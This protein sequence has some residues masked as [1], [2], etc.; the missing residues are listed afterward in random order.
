MIRQTILALLISITINSLAAALNATIPAPLPD[1][2]FVTVKE[3]HLSYNGQRLRLWGT[4]VVCDIKRSVGPE[5]DLRFDRL[6]DA[7]FNGL[8]LNLFDNVTFAR[9][10]DHT[11]P[12]YIPVTVKGSD[13][14]MDRLDYSIY[15]A[16]QRGLFFWMSLTP[17]AMIASDYD[18]LPDDGTRDR[19][20]KAIAEASTHLM[21]F[22]ERAEKVFQEF[23]RGIVEHVNPYTGKRYADEEAIA[24]YELS[25]ENDFVEAVQSRGLPGVAGE[26]L[27]AKWNAYLKEKYKTDDRLKH[28]WT[29]LN[30]GESLERGTVA[31]QPIINGVVTYRQGGV[32][33]EYESADK[34]NLTKYSY[35]RGEDL[36][37]FV[38]ELY[39]NHT[40]RMTAFL[41][42]LAKPGVGINVVPITPT[43][44]YGQ[45][46]TTY[47]AAA[48]G[49][50]VSTGVYGFALRPWELDKKNKFY[51]YMVRSVYHPTMEQPI[52]L[53]RA[54]NKPY[55]I[56]ECNDFRPNPYTT[57]FIARIAAYLIHQD[58]D[59]AFWFHWDAAGYLPELKTD[60]DYA[61]N[62]RLPIPDTNYPNA[63]IIHANDEA[64]LAATKAMGT[65]FKTG[66]VPPASNPVDITL[67]KDI[68]FNL[69]ASLQAP[70]G[71][72]G[73][74]LE[75]LIREKTWRYGTRIKYDPVGP[76]KLPTG[77]E[78]H[79]LI[80][81]GPYMSY[82]W[83]GDEGHF[84]VDAPAAK[85]YTGF[86]KP[87]LDFKNTKLTD[88]DR[89]FGMI[90]IV[91]E[92]GL[93]LEKSSSIL[94]TAVSRGRNTGMEVHPENL[95]TADVWQQGLAQMCTQSGNTPVIVDRIS[96][97]ITAPW[98]KGMHVEK[99][100]FLRKTF[101][102]STVTNNTLTLKA[103]EPTFYIRLTRTATSKSTP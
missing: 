83:N 40:R 75:A 15:L 30:A 25:N 19:W 33:K 55:L 65:L 47:Y 5:L 73:L 80:P 21:V 96:A 17:R 44:R 91:A 76:S 59:G 90:A 31:F 3:G 81:M 87:T 11:S 82:S 56:Y 84:R 68:L 103:D 32:Q 74:T 67:G 94:I 89:D 26:M 16:H 13:S 102:R 100:D 18:V 70:A 77:R 64:F 88:I 95:N 27:T 14:P 52:D 57:E 4:N 71:D 43:G 2:K 24:L 50:F 101:D 1:G 12:S 23:A 6:A 60:E 78:P 42:S 49:D 54:K 61:R 34:T 97:T 79:G 51:P 9:D 36:S 38:C 8:R 58:G 29:A 20:V 46:I 69:N 35:A 62:F 86:L 66:V 93:P 7:G 37:R 99:R 53:F 39:Q 92:D 48:C 22:D 63:A 72:S 45:S 41:R 98:L 85:V 28:A 10:K